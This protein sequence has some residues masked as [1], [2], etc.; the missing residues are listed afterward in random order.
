MNGNVKSAIE[1][2]KSEDPAKR[3]G[4]SGQSDPIKKTADPSAA[5]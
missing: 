1:N 2:L 3:A 5:I 4:E